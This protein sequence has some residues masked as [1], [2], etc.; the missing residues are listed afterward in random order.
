VCVCLVAALTQVSAR[1]SAPL[2]SRLKGESGLKMRRVMK[3]R[4]CIGARAATLSVRSRARSSLTGVARTVCPTSSL[5]RKSD[6]LRLLERRTTARFLHTSP[7]SSNTPLHRRAS[8]PRPSPPIPQPGKLQMGRANNRQIS[9][10]ATTPQ[11]RHL[12]D[13]H[14]EFYSKFIRSAADDRS[15]VRHSVRIVDSHRSS[16]RDKKDLEDVTR[17]FI[18]RRFS[19]RR[20][21]DDG[22]SFPLAGK[23]EMIPWQSA[24]LRRSDDGSVGRFVIRRSRPESTSDVSESGRVSRSSRS[25]G[26]YGP[27]YS[28]PVA[29]QASQ[30]AVVPSTLASDYRLVKAESVFPTAGKPGGDEHLLY[31]ALSSS[32]VGL[33]WLATV[34][35]ARLDKMLESMR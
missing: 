21:E 13:R 14:K 11:T 1:R 30:S 19:Q 31:S 2:S 35:V 24:V 17:T 20:S 26:I 15:A 25:A 33:C 10:S 32:W 16:R 5:Q 29:M 4:P 28:S 27:R 22:Q 7:R 12:P 23:L 6:R 18:R 9:P 34:G 8:N 3:A